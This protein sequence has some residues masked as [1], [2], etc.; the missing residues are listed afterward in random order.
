VPLPPLRGLSFLDRFLVIWIIL[1]MATGIILGN[2]VSS[3]GP[4]LQKG[5]FVDVSIPIGE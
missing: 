2:T 4:A 5:A 1:A 3:V